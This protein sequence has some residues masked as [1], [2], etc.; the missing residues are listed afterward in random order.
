[1][2]QR[3]F[4]NKD[5]SWFFHMAVI[6]QLTSLM[7]NLL[8]HHF[9]PDYPYVELLLQ[10]INETSLFIICLIFI[11]QVLLLLAHKYKNFVMKHK[12][13]TLTAGV[14]ISMIIFWLL[15]IDNDIQEELIIFFSKISLIDHSSQLTIILMI[16]FT[17]LLIDFYNVIQE[18]EPINEKSI[19]EMMKA[20]IRLV[21]KEHIFI[22]IAMFG[23]LH[24][25]RIREFA[26]ELFDYTHVTIITNLKFLEILIPATWCVIFFYYMYHKFMKNKKI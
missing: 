13:I 5:L 16:I 23:A 17:I 24:I 20:T 21:I 4:T 10:V 25:K 14:I 7:G 6:M 9:F 19:P 8:V 18:S 15:A 11:S 1:M 12:F 22:F 26:T 2:F 3:I